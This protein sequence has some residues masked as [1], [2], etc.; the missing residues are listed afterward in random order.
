MQIE[1]TKGRFG[2]HLMGGSDES[3]PTDPFIQIYVKSSSL[4][5][6]ADLAIS[7]RM[8]KATEIDRFIDDAI[9]ALQAIRSDAKGTLAAAN[10]S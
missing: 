1:Q 5:R 9:A 8:T 3:H 4:S 10:A 2:F 6:S 7:V